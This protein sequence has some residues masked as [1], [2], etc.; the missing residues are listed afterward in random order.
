[1]TLAGFETAIP[2]IKRRQNHALDRM[3][4][5]IGKMQQDTVCYWTFLRRCGRIFYTCEA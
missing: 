1:M 5:K 2:V 4:T 3:D